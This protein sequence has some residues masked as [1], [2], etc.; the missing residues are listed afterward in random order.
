MAGSGRRDQISDYQPA[1]HSGR[2]RRR[3]AGG[4]ADMAEQ[5]LANTRFEVSAAAVQRLL[6]VMAA[7]PTHGFGHIAVIR[8]R[9]SSLTLGEIHQPGR[10]AARLT[11]IP[12]DGAQCKS[13]CNGQTARMQGQQAMGETAVPTFVW[14]L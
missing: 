9:A 10:N 7:P 12:V 5:F 14:L 11:Y 4:K 13:A 2:W 1:T 6:S 3:N 8:L